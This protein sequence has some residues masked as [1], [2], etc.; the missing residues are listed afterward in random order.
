[1]LAYR[2]KNELAPWKVWQ[3]EEIKPEQDGWVLLQLSGEE[4]AAVRATLRELWAKS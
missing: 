2:T 4:L 1:M 3:G